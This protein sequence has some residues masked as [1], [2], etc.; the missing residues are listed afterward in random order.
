[1]TSQLIQFGVFRFYRADL[2]AVHFKTQFMVSL[3]FLCSN[4]IQFVAVSWE[5]YI[6]PLGKM[7]SGQFIVELRF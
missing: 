2:K 3:T 5:I 7:T 1:M 4:Q 6:Y